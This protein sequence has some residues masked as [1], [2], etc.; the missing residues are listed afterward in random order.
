[1]AGRS[2]DDLGTPGLSWV[3]LRAFARH[4]PHTSAIAR[5]VHGEA[6]AWGPT[7]HLLATVIDVLQVGNWQRAGKKGSP[8]PK[9]I[10]R[11]GDR[12]RIGTT[13]LSLDA[14]DKLLGYSPRT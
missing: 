10:T 1:M 13:V 6:A 11:P 12:K 8:R 14:M 4:A 7:E 3:D 9:P 5:S 2:L